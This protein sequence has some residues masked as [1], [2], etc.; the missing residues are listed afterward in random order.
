MD[1]VVIN[2]VL[3]VFL[4]LWYWKKHHTVDCGFLL[5]GVWAF[6]SVTGVF[7]YM[8]EPYT[9][10]LTLQPFLFL[11]IVFVLFGRM[12]I[13]PPKN[14]IC[15]EK[16]MVYK[17][18]S[19]FDACCVFFIFCSFVNLLTMDFDITAL[20]D[21]EGTADK[22]YD[23]ALE[24]SSQK[25]YSNFIERITM[26][27]TS[28][29][30][31]AAL[32]GLFNAI[33]QKRNKFVVLLSIAIYVP[34]ILTAVMRGSRSMIFS[35]VMMF[36]ACYLFYKEYIPKKTRRNI[37]KIGVF[38]GVFLMIYL[39]GV[40]IARFGTGDS[41]GDSLLSYFGQSMLN[42]NYGLA[43]S[44]DGTYM[45]ARTF[46][47]ILEW[48]GLKLPDLRPDVMFGTHFG[49]N[50]VTFIGMLLLDFNY[51][52]TVIVAIVLPWIIKKLCY[53]NTNTFSI[54]QLYLY[55]FF[56]NRLIFGVFV[57]GS[58]ADISYIV[59]LIFYIILK[60]LFAKI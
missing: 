32:I 48:V 12:Y 8:S 40:T 54:A 36:A 2:A 17:K 53:S 51:I 9:W 35:Q 6:V 19:L 41:A 37:Y 58:G 30:G 15:Y 60:L 56:L 16:S 24:S 46:K 23:D 39:F 31:T 4:L 11:F 3:Y 50:F 7:L 22:L 5:I 14:S 25:G 34:G 59:A 47:T 33:C 20:I 49:S 42:Y 13:Y 18:S 10:D 45:G 28:W 57:N 1:I 52:G 55:L 26:N 43:D 29:F 38:A 27:Y 21:I 44:F